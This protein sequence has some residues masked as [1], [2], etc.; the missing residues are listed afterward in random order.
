MPL[1]TDLNT[2]GVNPLRRDCFAALAAESRMAKN[3]SLALGTVLSSIVSW[4]GKSTPFSTEKRSLIGVDR[5]ARFSFHHMFETRLPAI[6]PWS[7]CCE[8][9]ECLD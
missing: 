5:V 4:Y 6:M 8:H 9:Y 1:H 7:R 3:K 2:K